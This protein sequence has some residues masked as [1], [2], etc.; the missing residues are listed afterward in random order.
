MNLPSLHKGSTS[1]STE[2]GLDFLKHL[3]KV[4]SEESQMER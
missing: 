2:A 1:V 3:G 4:A